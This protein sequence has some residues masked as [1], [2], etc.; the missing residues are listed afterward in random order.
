MDIELFINQL[1]SWAVAYG[2]KLIIAL[3]VLRIGW[4]AI[5]KLIGH[6]DKI[7][8]KKALDKMI[9][10]FLET[11]FNIGL[12]TLL[13]MMLLPYVGIETAGIAALVASAGVAIGLA[14]QGSLSNFA[15]GVI[16]LLLRPFKI[17]DYIE[18]SGYAGTVEGIKIFY[19]Q[20]VT[21]DNKVISIP[22]GG[23]ANQSL[24]NY[25]QKSTRR[26]DLV[27]GVGYEE[28]I[29]KVKQVL[30]DIINEEQL[31]L[32]APEPFVSVI[33]HG[34]SSVN[35]VVR[36]WCETEDYWTVHFNLLEQVKIRFDQEQ[37]K[38]PYPQLDVH[39][40]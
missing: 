37:I 1:V 2:L 35:F 33:E 11:V 27:F 16:I 28:D 20:L 7:L 22:N 19:T 38:I 13:L 5:N 8:E 26:V 23:L 15:G 17:G 32:K 12:K 39:T 4:T 6:V 29:I 34:A 31:I 10:T 36:V 18:T 24:V 40:H 9:R 14:L 21:P 25:S 30:M 3:I